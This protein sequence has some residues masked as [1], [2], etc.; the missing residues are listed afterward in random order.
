MMIV[1]PRASSPAIWGKL[2]DRG[3]YVRSRTTNREVEDWRI[4]LDKQPWL[5]APV[6]PA[7]ANHTDQ[8][9]WMRLTPDFNRD[10]A[11]GLHNLPWGFVLHPSVLP[12]SGRGWVTGVVSVSRD[13]IGRSYPLV[14]Y[15]VVNSAWLEHH[16]TASQ[17]WLYWLAQL[18]ACH[19][20]PERQ[21]T[22]DLPARVERL[23][24]LH[25]PGWGSRLFRRWIGGPAA[26]RALVEGQGKNRAS[27]L[28]GVPALPWANWPQQLWT[29]PA[30]SAQGWFWQQDLEGGFLD[31]RSLRAGEWQG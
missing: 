4:W 5:Y 2:P 7:A 1:K 23:W 31:A 18:V 22:G 26:Y 14:I 27:E 3:D 28:R 6:A 10:K 29:S 21:S 19:V 9:H 15:Q 12:F 30:S 20:N 17:G 25:N 13:S 11:L 24:A 8:H 16:L